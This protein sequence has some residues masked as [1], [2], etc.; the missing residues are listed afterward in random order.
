M[1]VFFDSPVNHFQVNLF[2]PSLSVLKA[3]FFCFDE[4]SLVSNS[5]KILS[6]FFKILRIWIFVTSN[7]SAKLQLSYPFF[8]FIFVK[9]N[10][11]FEKVNVKVLFF[12]WALVLL[13]YLMQW[14]LQTIVNLY[15]ISNQTFSMQ[16]FQFWKWKMN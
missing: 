15:V 4:I 5:Q 3:L 10:L 16:Y 11:I 9:F 7:F 2:S 1:G 8:F 12:C 14:C 6:P 13:L